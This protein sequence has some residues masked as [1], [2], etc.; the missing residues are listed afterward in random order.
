MVTGLPERVDRV[1]EMEDF[2]HLSG[3]HFTFLEFGSLERW[4]NDDNEMIS[5]SCYVS[6]IVI[7]ILHVFFCLIF[8]ITFLNRV[9]IASWFVQIILIVPVVSCNC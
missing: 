5:D 9:I 7:S 4:G 6:S 2:L 3:P 8:I 1:K